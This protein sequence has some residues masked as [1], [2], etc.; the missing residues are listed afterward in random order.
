MT[1]IFPLAVWQPGTLQP[2]TPVNDNA[3]RVEVLQRGAI[4]ILS[5]PPGSPADG[6]VHIVGASPTGAWSSFSEHDVVLWRAGTWYRFSPF[7]GWIKQ[8]GSD[9]LRYTGTAWVLVSGGGGGAI[10]VQDDGTTIVSSP[11]AINFTGDGVTVT[12]A[13]GVATVNIPGGG[14]S[15]LTR[16]TLFGGQTGAAVIFLNDAGL[17]TTAE[18]SGGAIRTARCALARGPTGKWYFEC[19]VHA[20]GDS[21][22][23]TPAIG[24]CQSAHANVEMGGSGSTTSGAASW[25][26]LSNGTGKYH[27]ASLQA[28]GSAWANGDVIMVAVDLDSGNIWWGRNGTWFDSGNPSTGANP[29]YTNLSSTPMRMRPGITHGSNSDVTLRLSSSSFSYTPPSG[30]SAWAS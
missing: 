27:N 8:V 2:S 23:N 3:L 5:T 16:A 17:R 25:A 14:G 19:L 10:P 4:S 18:D 22:V 9:V 13:S 28:Y 29:A 1:A 30:Y 26:M 21:G 15:S 24:V 7:L 11:S 12:D 20:R 6:D